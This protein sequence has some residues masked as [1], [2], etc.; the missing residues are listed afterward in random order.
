MAAAKQK[1]LRSEIKGLSIF[2]AVL[3]K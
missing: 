1:G 3:A 2:F